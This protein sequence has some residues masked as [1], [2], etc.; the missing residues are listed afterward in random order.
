M[1]HITHNIVRDILNTLD[2]PFDSH[3]VE[4]ALIVKHTEVFAKD[5][6]E[7][8]RTHHKSPLRLFSANF[9]KWLNAEFGSQIQKGPK[10]STLSLSGREVSNQQWFKVRVPIT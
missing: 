9:A 7:F 2:S 4:F 10:V 1:V 6:A 8:C 3:D 5:L